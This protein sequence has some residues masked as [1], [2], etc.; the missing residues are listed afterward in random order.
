MSRDDSPGPAMTGRRLVFVTR[1]GC[2][3]C[4]DALGKLKVPALL[5]GR[6]IVV[7]DVDDDP[8]LEERYGERVPV[9]LSSAGEVLAEGPLTRA[10][11]RRVVRGSRAG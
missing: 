2:G 6:R 8:E 3:I 11:A 4:D 5:R 10:G 9:V 1:A 7:V